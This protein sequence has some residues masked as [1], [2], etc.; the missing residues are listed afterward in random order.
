METLAVGPSLLI[1]A[2]PSASMRF[3][4]VQAVACILHTRF[5]WR[6][7]LTTSPRFAK[8]AASGPFQLHFPH[9]WPHDHFAQQSQLQIA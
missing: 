3:C 2:A 5:S 8:A 1:S 4:S 6:M 7:V 9:V